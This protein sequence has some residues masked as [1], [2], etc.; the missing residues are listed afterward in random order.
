MKSGFIKSFAVQDIITLRILHRQ[1]SG[2]DI[3]RICI[4]IGKMHGCVVAAAGKKKFSVI[5][6]LFA[7]PF[8]QIQPVI[9]FI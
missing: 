7:D 1:K 5:K 2:L 8:E 6:G 3:G 9:A 4:E